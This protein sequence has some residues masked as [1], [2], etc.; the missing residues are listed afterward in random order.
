MI[1]IMLAIRKN[2]KMFAKWL[3]AYIKHTRNFANIELLILA[4]EEDTWNQDFF[5]YYNLHV[6][7]ENYNAGPKARH[8]F[9]NQMAKEAKGDWLWHMCDDHYLL[10]GYDEY[11]VN[12][13]EEKKILSESVNIIVPMVENSGSISHILSRGYYN[14]VGRIGYHGN[15]DSY[16]NDV[17]E[18]MVYRERLYYPEKPVMIDF[19]VDQTI[20]TPEHTQT[21]PQNINIEFHD[22]TSDFTKAE[23]SKDARKLYETI[24]G[25]K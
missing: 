23:I 19:T 9:Y 21:G 12:Y 14:A 20:M 7:R 5:S 2:S 25:G 15:I 10:D 24:K 6:L 18:Q 22:F 3:I 11:L 16:L 8:I 17:H 4:N 13:I 1:T